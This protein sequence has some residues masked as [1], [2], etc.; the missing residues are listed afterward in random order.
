MVL[1]KNCGNKYRYKGYSTTKKNNTL[2]SM[3][4][5]FQLYGSS[6]LFYSVD[7]KAT[8]TQHTHTHHNTHT[9]NE[10]LNSQESACYIQTTCTFQCTPF[11][12]AI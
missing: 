12:I 7:L 8:H 11:L 3:V 2:T 6:F 5:F 4:K 1:F 10:V 9:Y